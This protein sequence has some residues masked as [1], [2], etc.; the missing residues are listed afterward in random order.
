[1]V[2]A[3]KTIKTKKMRESRSR[4]S[5]IVFTIGIIT[6]FYVLLFTRFINEVQEENVP[7]TATITDPAKIVAR[8]IQSKKAKILRCQTTKGPF[9]VVLDRE[10]S[11]NSVTE[12][13]RMI[14]ANFFEDIA[15]FRVNNYIIQFGVRDKTFKYSSNWERDLNKVPKESRQPWK[16]GDMSM[17]GGTHMLIVKHPNMYMGINNHDTVVG[18][19]SENDMRVIDAMYAYNDPIDNPNGDLGPDQVKI[20]LEGWKYLN[21]NFPLIDKITSCRLID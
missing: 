19:I 11:P 6:V 1:V 18:T 2:E 5:D 21:Q 17:I 15:I 12:L 4:S 16:R 8:E 10:T 13:T 9:D 7:A 14:H 20:H 3:S